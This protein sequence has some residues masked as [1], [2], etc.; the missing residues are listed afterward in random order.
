MRKRYGYCRLVLAALIP[1]VVL[2]SAFPASGFVGNTRTVIASKTVEPE[3]LNRK[4]SVEQADFGRLLLAKQAETLGLVSWNGAED[5]LLLSGSLLTQRLREQ[6]EEEE[7]AR[8]KEEQRRR[9]K[10]E[11]A[12]QEQAEKKAQEEAAKKAAEEEKERRAASQVSYSDEDYQVLLKIVQA[13]AGICDEKGKILVANVILN[14]VRSDE[15]PD[16]IREVVYQ[17]SQFQPVST[18]RINS[19]HVTEETVRCVDRALSGEDYSQGALYFMNRR[20]S[21]SSASWFDRNLNY[22]FAHDGHEFFK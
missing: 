21:G 10:Q 6:R 22:L 18:G 9:E 14:R 12:R 16:S 7:E 13:E 11:Q 3:R 5:A 15:F 4:A 1:T 2:A 17:P 8:R 19:V 20:G